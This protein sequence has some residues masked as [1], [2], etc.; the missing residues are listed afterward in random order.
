M[1][2]LQ[3]AEL[4]QPTPVVSL[5][6]CFPPLPAHPQSKFRP[7]L[8]TG[9]PEAFTYP[10]LLAN[11]WIKIEKQD[12]THLAFYPMGLQKQQQQQQNKQTNKKPELNKTKKL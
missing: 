11:L 12:L 4:L 5:P 2:C 7:A 3:N 9:V 1:K 10:K 8:K 6:L